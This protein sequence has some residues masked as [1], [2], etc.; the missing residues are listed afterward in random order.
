MAQS[1][2]VTAQGITVY[3]ACV[4]KSRFQTF[5]GRDKW[6]V[7]LLIRKDDTE[8]IRKLVVAIRSDDRVKAAFPDLKFN[9]KTFKFSP[10]KDDDHQPFKDGDATGLEAHSGCIYFQP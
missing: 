6:S 8:T 2:G 1:Q 7:R 10:I 5:D 4:T 3:T 9:S